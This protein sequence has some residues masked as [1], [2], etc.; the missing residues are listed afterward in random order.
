MCFLDLDKSLSAVKRPIDSMKFSSSLLL[1]MDN[2]HVTRASEEF[3]RQTC[4]VP[5]VR[6]NFNRSKEKGIRH[7]I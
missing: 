3:H 2:L 4:V 7:H 1:S 5:H 6:L